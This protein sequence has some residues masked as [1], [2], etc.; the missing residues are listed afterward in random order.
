MRI[1]MIFAV[2]MA[3]G[4]LAFLLGLAV[5]ATLSEPVYRLSFVPVRR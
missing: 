4:A 1:T 5:A 2:T 3:A